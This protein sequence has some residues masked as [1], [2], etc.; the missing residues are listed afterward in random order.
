MKA[1]HNLSQ[2][3]IERLEQIGF[4]WQVLR[5]EYDKKFEKHCH[6]FIAFKDEFGHCNIPYKYTGNPSFGK[7]CSD[8][9]NAY[10]KI[11]KGMKSNSNLSQDRIDR[12]EEIGFQWKVFSVTFEERCREFIAFKD[13]FGHC[14][15]PYIYTGNPSLG[16]FC[17]NMRTAYRKIQKGMKAK[18]N[19]SQDRIERLEEIG[20]EWQPSRTVN[21]DKI[22]EQRCRELTSF[23]EEFGHC[24]VPSRYAGNSSLGH[25]SGNMRTAYRKIQKG[26][27]VNYNLS[28]DRIEILEDIGFRW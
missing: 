7:W 15:I 14:N 4:Q 8:I 11:Q 1:N 25:W 21:D 3:K 5:T 20:F 27:K 9:R 28:Q 18:S 23:K 26:M 16:R 24:N 19:L 13:E 12:L 2:E 22:F 10:K 17:G 6:E